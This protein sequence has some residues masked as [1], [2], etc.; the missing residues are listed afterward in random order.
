M[1]HLANLCRSLLVSGLLLLMTA[2]LA[3]GPDLSR[4]SFHP[5]PL[6]Y[7]LAAATDQYSTATAPLIPQEALR[8]DPEQ[9]A[10]A[11]AKYRQFLDGS[12]SDRGPYAI[13][14]SEAAL[15]LGQLQQDAGDFDAAL[16]SYERS[17][18]VLRINHGLFSVEQVPV[19]KAIVNLHV[20]RGDLAG[21]SAMQE[22]L[23]NLQTRHHGMEDVASVP[24]LLEWADWNVDLFLLQ[25]DMAPYLFSSDAEQLRMRLRDPHLALA[26]T[27]YTT[28]L[29]L[30]KQQPTLA[31]ERLVTTERKLAA[32]NFIFN[33]RVRDVAQKLPSYSSQ[34]RSFNSPGQ[35][36]EQADIMHF[37]DGSSALRRAIDYSS[38]VPDPDYD[39]IAARMMELGD[40]YL[41]FDRRTAALETYEDALH[42]MTSAQ[43]PQ[44]DVDRIM[45]PGM[46]VQTPDT[47]YLPQQ[48]KRRTPHAGYID[49]EFDLTR[50]GMA[51][52]PRIIGSSSDDDTRIRRELIHTIRNCRFRPKFVAG[53]AVNDETIRL[54]YYYHL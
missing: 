19:M 44:E 28:A 46:P 20:K 31:D 27:H 5:V 50:Y 30:M 10:A 40:W 13:A 53:S 17:M 33:R 35:V 29:Q 14:I 1:N 37:A 15:A 47:S 51:V 6:T 26:Y 21:A 34:E 45:A 9:R 25:D 16:V 22:S 54:R 7:S 4:L 18:Q 36:L 23:F 39:F 43:L 32:V 24:A 41:L 12:L 42:L 38:S 11:I 2:Q 48:D 3:A 49:V 52:K 8:L